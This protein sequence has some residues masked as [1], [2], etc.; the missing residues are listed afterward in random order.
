M[1]WFLNGSYIGSGS[2]ANFTSPSQNFEIGVG[3]YDSEGRYAWASKSVTIDDHSTC[4][5]MRKTKRPPSDKK[6]GGVK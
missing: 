1:E 2:S 4:D 5:A 3:A 6:S